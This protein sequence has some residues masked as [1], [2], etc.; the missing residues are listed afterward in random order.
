MDNGCPKCEEIQSKEPFPKT[1]MCL[2]CKIAWNDA[3]I[4]FHKTIADELKKE[5]EHANSR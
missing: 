5:K 2:D 4:A 3:Q 1:G